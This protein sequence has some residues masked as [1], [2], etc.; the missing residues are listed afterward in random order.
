MN[1]EGSLFDVPPA[2][3][4][5]YLVRQPLGTGTTG[6]VFQ[7]QDPASPAPVTIKL[8]KVDLSPDDANGVARALAR[9]VNETPRHG[10]LVEPLDAGLDESTAYFVTAFV[11]GDSLEAAL[12]DFGPAAIEDL[13]PRLR[14]LAAGLDAVHAGGLVHGALHPRDILVSP[15]TTHITGVG[16]AP[17]LA[18]AAVALPLRRPYSAPEVATG[19][20]ATAASDQFS[21]AAIAFEWLFGRRISGPAERLVE[22]RTLPGVDRDALS[23]AFTIA[24]A[25]DPETRFGSCHAFAEAV[26]AA[27]DMDQIAS[28]VDAALIAPPVDRNDPVGPF[29]AE[30]ARFEAIDP[31]G[32]APLERDPGPIEVP[33]A[34]VRRPRDQPVAWNSGMAAPEK[35]PE[36][37]G[38]GVLVATLIVGL[39]V[40]FA[41]GYM[42]TPRAL[43]STPP[44][45]MAS[46]AGTDAAV[47]PAQAPFDSARSTA[48][49]AQGQRAPVAPPPASASARDDSGELRRDRAG[50]ASG[51]EGGP[52]SG[53]RLLVRSSPSGATVS[54]DGVP[55]GVTPLALRDVDLGSRHVVVARR[56]Y[57]VEDQRVVLTSERPSRSI[58]V[59][60][61][62]ESPPSDYA[63]AGRSGAIAPKLARPRAGEGGAA[64]T[65]TLAV[66]SRPPGASVMLNGKPTG[67]TPLNLAA[68]EPGEYRVALTLPGYQPFATTVRVVAGARAR[69]AASLSV[70]ERE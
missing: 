9:L 55:R 54:V 29:L 27:V 1:E 59:R 14:S 6:P 13:V 57:I 51:R 52:S 7:A 36:R 33:V 28:L 70:Q 32:S 24:L 16:V 31:V 25:P 65:G 50:A 64:S 66:E 22:V 21:L 67:T 53:G 68:L 60:L 10:A 34:P 18:R 44:R 62:A 12:R 23:N 41:A 58:E 46:A 8:F 20:G 56:G 37:F 39:I 17:I 61:V 26:A 19:T 5:R 63:A 30:P 45:K 38:G 11:E 3:I 47:A 69:A 42:A 35:T 15:D 40:G 43:Q 49:V 4:G 48:S 2:A